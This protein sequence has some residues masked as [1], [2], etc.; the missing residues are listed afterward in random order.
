MRG[1]R[2]ARIDIKKGI[3]IKIKNG[4]NVFY[5]GIGVTI[6]DGIDVFLQRTAAAATKYPTSFPTTKFPTRFP[7]TGYP[8]RFPTTGYPSKYVRG[9]FIVVPPPIH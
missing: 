3:D 5:G 6:K 2:L 7:T 9:S 8:S 1:W 4:I